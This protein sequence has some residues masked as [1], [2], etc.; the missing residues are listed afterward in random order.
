MGVFCSRSDGLENSD[1][2]PAGGSAGGRSEARR[3]VLVALLHA[4]ARVAWEPSLAPLLLDSLDRPEAIAPTRGIENRLER[5]LREVA[6]GGDTRDL[7]R[8]VGAG[9]WTTAELVLETVR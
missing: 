5:M 7:V 4:P 9:A 3:E 2:L 1:P 6:A 8:R